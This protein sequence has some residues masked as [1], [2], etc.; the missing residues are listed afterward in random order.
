MEDNT[1]LT[2]IVN[3]A[4]EEAK[5]ILTQAKTQ[6]DQRL[7]GMESQVSALK[8]KGDKAIAEHADLAR[9]RNDSLINTEERRIALKARE[10]LGHRVIQ[11]AK[12]LLLESISDSS[13]EDV[14][15][16]WIAE[17]VLGI[18]ENE[19]VVRCS[20]KEKLS[21]AILA[22]AEALVKEFTGRT[23]KLSHADGDPLSDQGVVVSSLDGKVSFNNQVNTRFRRYDQDV[24]GLISG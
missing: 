9:R 21:D 10:D 22:K 19:A 14:M 13:Y 12:S 7:A 6:A 16:K 8:S 1:L 17:G 3:D 2:G 5:R 18:N 23:V 15:A 20:F 4:E 11:G 24:K